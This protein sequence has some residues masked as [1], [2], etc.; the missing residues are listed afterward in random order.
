MH[1]YEHAQTFSELHTGAPFWSQYHT[2]ILI[3]VQ[4]TALQSSLTLQT[5]FGN[6]RP[7]GLGEKFSTPKINATYIIAASMGTRSIMPMN[8]FFLGIHNYFLLLIAAESCV[9]TPE[10]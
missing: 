9:N 7:V 3:F 8:T 10:S 1:A 6:T 5:T 2:P 4:S